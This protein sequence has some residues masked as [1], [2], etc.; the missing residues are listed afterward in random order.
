MNTKVIA[1][2]VFGGDLNPDVDA[3]TAEL[4]QAGY[5]LRIRRPALI[6]PVIRQ[7]LTD[8]GMNAFPVTT[9]AL[10]VEYRAIPHLS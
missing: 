9:G 3:A 7:Q 6:I 8:N 1:R 2:A 10:G 5:S 4:R